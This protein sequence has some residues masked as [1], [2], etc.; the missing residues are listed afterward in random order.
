VDPPSCPHR[1]GKKK[2]KPKK[3]RGKKIKHTNRTIPPFSHQVNIIYG[4]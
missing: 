4:K 3:E 1:T 2:D